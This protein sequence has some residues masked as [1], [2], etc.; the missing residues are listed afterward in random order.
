M[1]RCRHNAFRADGA[2]G[3]YIIILPELDAVIVVTADLEDMRREIN[4]IWQTILP[5]LEN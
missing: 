1:W 3:Q 2:A 5:A 4:L